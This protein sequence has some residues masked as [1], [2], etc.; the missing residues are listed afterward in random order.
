M[1]VGVLVVIDNWLI[2]VV[3]FVIKLVC[4][5]EI[6]IVSNVWVVEFRC[7]CYDIMSDLSDIVEWMIY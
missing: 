1:I 2:C 6:S 3:M 7:I 5:C 4:C